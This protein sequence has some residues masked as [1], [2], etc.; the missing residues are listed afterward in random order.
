M[1]LSVIL[2]IVFICNQLDFSIG[3]MYQK[4]T[5]SNYSKVFFNDWHAKT[6]FPKQ[7]FGGMFIAIAMTGLDQEM[8]QKNISC[9][10][11]GDAQ[12]NVVTF[13]FVLLIVNI[14]FLFLGALLYIYTNESGIALQTNEAGKIISDNVFPTVALNHLGVLSAIFFIIGL[15]SAAYPS[16]DGALTALTSVFCLDFLGLKDDETKTEAQKTKIRHT[17]HIG[18]SVLLF[19][20]III[21]KL[22]NNDA[23][24]NNLFTVAGYTYGP[25]LGLY[26][27]GLFTKKAVNDKW[28][29]LICVISVA[30]CYVLNE[31]SQQWFGGYKFGFELLIVN[32]AFTFIGLGLIPAKKAA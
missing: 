17:V 27:F 29:P 5:E 22:I 16:A 1:L 25:L 10:T 32:G 30:L 11:L 15:I 31:F 28:V 26:A 2:S 9:K 21:F 7:F 4:V 18:F 24:I 8:M 3:D 6:F 20:V 23:V 19:L 12:K 13:T 14:L